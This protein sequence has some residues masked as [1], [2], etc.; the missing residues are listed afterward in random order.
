MK[1]KGP[2]RRGWVQMFGLSVLLFFAVAVLSAIPFIRDWELRFADTFFRLSPSPKQK[3]EVVLV[4]LDDESLQRYGRW[5]S[6]LHGE[7]MRNARPISSLRMVWPHRMKPDPFSP[8]SPS[9]CRFHS[10]G[11]VSIRFP[12]G[13]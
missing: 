8:Q 10:A 7:W 1:N 12:L 3:S 6:K 9:W 4:T 11:M 13:L 2:N 5:R